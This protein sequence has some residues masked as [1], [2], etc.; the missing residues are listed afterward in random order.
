[1]EYVMILLG[2]IL[3][4]TSSANLFKQLE[5][6]YTNLYWVVALFLSGV[7]IGYTVGYY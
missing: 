5:D 2:L 6:S 4:I 3:V 1:M 7:F